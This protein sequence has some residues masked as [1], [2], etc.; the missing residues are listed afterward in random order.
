ML[1]DSVDHWGFA[2]GT[3]LWALALVANIFIQLVDI[4]HLFT[5]TGKLG[6]VLYSKKCRDCFMMSSVRMDM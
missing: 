4:R 5:S 2:C 6:A 1:D 3:S